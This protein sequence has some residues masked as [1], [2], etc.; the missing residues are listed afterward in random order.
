[1][2]PQGRPYWRWDGPRGSPTRIC[3]DRIPVLGC[4]TALGRF[5]RQR[6]GFHPLSEDLP[7][8]SVAVERTCYT[9]VGLELDEHFHDLGR[10]DPAIQGDANWPRSGS[11]V[12]RV[13]ATVTEINARV[14]TSRTPSRGHASPK[15]CKVARRVKSAPFAG[16]PGP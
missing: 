7:C 6:A 12:P 3:P 14:R 11:I 9:S 10:R 13:A 15:A 8:N 5:L 2:W 1:S 16:S 4:G